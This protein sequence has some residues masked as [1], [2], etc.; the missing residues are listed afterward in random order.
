[1]TTTGAPPRLW[2]FKTLQKLQA[3]LSTPEGLQASDLWPEMVADRLVKLSRPPGGPQAEEYP[4][5]SESYIEDRDKDRG[6]SDLDAIPEDLISDD[7]GL[8]LVDIAYGEILAAASYR[9][10]TDHQ[11]SLITYRM[12]GMT[13][14]DIADMLKCPKTTVHREYTAAIKKLETVPWFGLWSV[15]AE[16]FRLKVSEVRYI[17]THYTERS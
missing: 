15:I 12:D 5:Y 9:R 8:P 16:E 2:E 4:A 1:M 7:A 3:W 14:R 10:L 17:L 6:D 11:V 13:V